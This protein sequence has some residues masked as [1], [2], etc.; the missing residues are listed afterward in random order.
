MERQGVVG[1][2]GCP[3]VW[4]GSTVPAKKNQVNDPDD[5]LRWRRGGPVP[6]E[7]MSVPPRGGQ[8]Q[9]LP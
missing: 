1:G 2:R 9:Q 8:W 3:E 6:E 4:W 5:G 7:S